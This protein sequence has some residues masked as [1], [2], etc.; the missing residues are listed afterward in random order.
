MRLT[1]LFEIA[2]TALVIGMTFDDHGYSTQSIILLALLSTLYITFL[3]M[4]HLGID[5]KH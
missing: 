1:E 4:K 5:D 3:Y 2:I